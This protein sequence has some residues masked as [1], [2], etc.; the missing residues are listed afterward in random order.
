MDATTEKS[1]VGRLSLRLSAAGEYLLMLLVV[2]YSATWC[3]YTS[4]NCNSALRLAVPLLAALILLRFRRIPA[5]LWQRVALTGVYLAVYLLAT[6]YNG[7]RFVLYFALPLLLLMLY[8]GL[9]GD[10]SVYLLYRLADI[11]IVLT[12]LSLGFFLF[13]TVLG[14]IPPSSVTT[15]YWGES[16]RTCPT[17]F[18]LY[19][20]AQR[21]RFFGVDLP[22]NCGVFPE[23]PGF[24]AFLVV[25]VAAEVLLRRRLRWGRVALL[26]A[27]TLTTLSAKAL[28]LTAAV[29][30]LRYALWSPRGWRARRGR[31]VA[32]P[33][34][35]VG[36]SVAAGVLLWDK[37]Q[38]VSGGM[39]LDDVAACLKA[40]RTAPI[41]GTGYWNDASIVPYF[42]YPDRYNDGLSMGVAV[43]LA[44]GGLYLSALYWRPAVGCIRRARP[45]RGWLSLVLIYTGLLL[46]GNITYH[47]LTLLLIAVFSAVGRERAYDRP[48]LT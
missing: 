18:H 48:E 38:T 19:Y 36:L 41:F 17:Y 37:L 22:R 44:Q 35:G 4:A 23:A 30:A 34:L 39:R 20:E 45:R 5:R 8:T 42:S 24:A 7:V 27:A 1:S 40:F 12:A 11:V 6:R 33:V 46:T 21:I 3:L 28:I 47:F 16:W 14:W 13:G 32:L 15:F 9:E 25:A 2:F 26:T 29:L 31:V 10:R 43:L